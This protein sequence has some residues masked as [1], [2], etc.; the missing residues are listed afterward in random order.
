M[1]AT[2]SLRLTL[3]VRFAAAMAA[4]LMAMALL[5]WFAIRETLDRQIDTSLTNVASIQAAAITEPES[6]E[7]RIREWEV[8]P[9]EAASIQ[10]V[11]RFTQVWSAEGESL[12]RSRYLTRDLPLDTMALLRAGAGEIARVDQEFG[13]MDIRSLYYPLGRLGEPHGPHVLQVAAP[14]E[15]HDATLRNAGLLLLGIVIVAAGMTFAGAWWLADRAVQP[16]AEIVDQAEEIGARTLKRRIGAWA[17]IREYQRL[18]HVLNDMLDRLEAA[19]ES[20]RRFTADASHELRSPLTALR[21]E[22]ELA[23]RRER[24]PEEYRRVIDSALEEVERLSRTAEDLLTLA[25]SDAGVMQPRLVPVDLGGLV[26]GVAERSRVPAQTRR[27][28]LQVEAGTGPTVV[29]DPDLVG[30]LV[31][32]LVENAVKYT[33]GGGRVRVEVAREKESGLVIVEDTGPGIPAADLGRVFERFHRVEDS[34]T[35]E[36]DGGGAGL[37]LAI[38]R[39]IAVAHAGDLTV[40]NRPEGGTRFVARLPILA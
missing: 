14:L 2:R 20:Q 5:A 15:A 40:E 38:A 13:G 1:S 22:L 34:R 30:R 27:V 10:D 33:P 29:A 25:R 17:D 24:S 35:P 32:N 37:G 9:E 12:L 31:R 16:V 18:V 8:T 6:G 23:R 21:G 28:E 11:A 19:F 4:G 39:S 26:R 7:M 36:R 3:A